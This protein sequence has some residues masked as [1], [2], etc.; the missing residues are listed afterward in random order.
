MTNQRISEH[1]TRSFE[2]DARTSYI[3]V[4]YPRK[5]YTWFAKSVRDRQEG[6]LYER[7][8]I[9]QILLQLERWNV[10]TRRTEGLAAE[11]RSRRSPAEAAE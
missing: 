10:L 4:P 5:D 3:Y 7:S 8:Y 11:E 9:E 6:L 1:G 2:V